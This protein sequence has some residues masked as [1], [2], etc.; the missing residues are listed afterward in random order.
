MNL[1]KQ[2]I[3]N[4]GDITD[5]NETAEIYP[6]VMDAPFSNTDDEH[7]KNICKTLPNF[8]DQIIMFIMEK[9][10]NYAK[11]SIEP[12]VGKIYQI[13]KVSETESTIRRID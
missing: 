6:L 1:A 2:H 11:E 8:C 9:D 10:Y 4:D 5:D 7:I 12:K 13:D 3:I